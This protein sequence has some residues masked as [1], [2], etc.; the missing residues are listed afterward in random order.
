M[1]KQPIEQAHDADLRLSYA[2]LRRAAQRAREMAWR[3]G[4]AIVVS[5]QGVIE[6]LPPQP[7]P[8]PTVQEPPSSYED[9]R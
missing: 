8:A 2:A 1:N 5:R 3:T 4:T 9:K 6:H 7:W